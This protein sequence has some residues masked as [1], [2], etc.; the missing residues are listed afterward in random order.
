MSF[1]MESSKH[2]LLYGLYYVNGGVYSS[3]RADAGF[4]RYV[5]LGVCS[6]CILLTN[7]VGGLGFFWTTASRRLTDT[8]T[9]LGIINSFTYSLIISPYIT[10]SYRRE[11]EILLDYIVAR[12]RTNDDG[13]RTTVYWLVF[14]FSV[15]FAYSLITP[16]DIW[17]LCGDR[18]NATAAYHDLQHHI[19]P[20]PYLDR[21]PSVEIFYWLYV[22]EMV[23]L[24]TMI[25]PGIS[26]PA[27]V[28]LVAS[29]MS[30][31]VDEYCMQMRGLSA[32]IV[33]GETETNEIFE[34]DFV[35]LVKEYQT[36]IKYDNSQ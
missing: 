34:R 6:T 31:V 24:V 28:I 23:L 11:F 18:E 2:K 10:Y 9:A 13:T 19:V 36:F 4:W 27:F 22:V 16:I 26:Q 21:I 35:S 7:V 3:R 1:Q 12:P 29:E 14:Q 8:I 5:S 25:V 30:N 20:L 15:S 17:L 33:A 32:K